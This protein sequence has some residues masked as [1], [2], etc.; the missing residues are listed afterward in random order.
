MFS[1]PCPFGP[2]NQQLQSHTEVIKERSYHV[3]PR[4]E[5]YKILWRALISAVTLSIH[6]LFVELV[7]NLET[8]MDCWRDLDGF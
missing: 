8:K 5:C 1:L 7:V 2:W 6:K 3:R 4:A